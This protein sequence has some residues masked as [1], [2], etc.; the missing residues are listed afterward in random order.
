MAQLN[1]DV[2]RYSPHSADETEVRTDEIWFWTGVTL[3]CAVWVI[4][5]FALATRF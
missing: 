2:G 1:N 5:A 4:G 3:S